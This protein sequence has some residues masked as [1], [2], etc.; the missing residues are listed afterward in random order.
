M[1]RVL[2]VHDDC[3]LVPLFADN[4]RRAGEYLQRMWRQKE[5]SRR[6]FIYPSGHTKIR[7]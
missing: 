3:V 6:D 1:F 4:L 5:R 7:A 2:D